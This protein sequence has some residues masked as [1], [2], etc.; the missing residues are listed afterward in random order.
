[1]FNLSE[2]SLEGKVAIVT[3]GSRGIGK[4]I[5]QGFAK[6]G[7]SVIVTSRKINDL[8]ETASEITAAGGEAFPLAANLGLLDDVKT[9]V[10]TVVRRYGKIDILVN[11]AGNAPAASTVLDTDERLWDKIMGLNLKGLFFMSQACANVMKEQG[12]GKII[13]IGSI[14]G[15]NPEPGACVYSISKAGV[16]MVTKA[17]A[18]ELAGMNIQVNSICP[19]PIVTKMFESQWSHLP[20]DEAQRHELSFGHQVPMGRIGNPDDI[21]GAAIY[22]ASGASS[23]TTGAELLIDGGMMLLSG[24]AAAAER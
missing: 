2:F 3:G 14:N 7:A 9:V 5:A 12:R 21:V 17:F 20:E 19:G 22:L 18:A 23:Y 15:H 13:N 6:A 4:A 11:N 1:M 10:D 16:R 24:M 8:Q